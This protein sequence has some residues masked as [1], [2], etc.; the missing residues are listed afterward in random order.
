M[1]KFKQN[2]IAI[3]YDFD[4][5]LS[6][7][8]MQEYTILPELG[9]DSKKFW[10]ECTVE[11]KKHNADAMLTYMRLLIE[12]ME[13]N[14]KGLNKN[15]LKKLA[16]NIEYF[17]GVEEW[18]DRINNY[19]ATN[20]E[21]KIKVEHYIIS[22]GLKEILSGVTIKKHFTEMFASEYYFDYNN[23][24]KFPTIVVNDTAKTQYLFRINKGINDINESINKHMPDSERRIPFSSMLYIGDGMT[25]VPCM[26]IAKKNGGYAMAVYPKGD[27]DNKKN[28][29]EL[30]QAGRIDYFAMADY[31]LGTDL[32]KRIKLIINKIGANIL[33]EKEKF[34]FRKNV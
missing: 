32:D 9:E 4:G 23:I 5:T 13:S 11:A 29:E 30:V 12:K 16:K 34:T 15:D 1:A 17:A 3:V 10:D 26:T 2:I 20:F 22:A 21:N 25:D 27:G 14:K 33:L 24:A 31:S 28:C 6:P 8:P 19:I 18:F 7:Q